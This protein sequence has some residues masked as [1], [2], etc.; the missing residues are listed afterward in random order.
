MK[1]IIFYALLAAVVTSTGCKRKDDGS[2]E[3]MSAGE[4]A[5]KTQEVAVKTAEKAA[6]VTAKAEDV[7]ADLNKSVEE[8][9]QQV[10]GFDKAQV[11]AY[12]DQ[13]KDIILEKKDQVTAL[14]EQVKG[15]S[16]TEAL[17]EKGKEIKGQISQYT[18]QVNGLKERY[19]VYLNALKGLG[20]DLSAYGL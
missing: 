12:A 16:M 1:Q 2:T 15:L 8:I 3:L 14:T 10:A 18:E 17:G 11:I 7:M 20:V 19:S 6:E 4:V 9:K 13:Y 5:E